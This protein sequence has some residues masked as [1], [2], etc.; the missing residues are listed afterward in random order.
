MRTATLT[1]ATKE[2]DITLS[3]CLDGSGATD[4]HTQIG[5]FDHMLTALA[6]HA[7]F[8][9]TIDAR[10][11]IQVDGHHTVED[12]GIL[13][14]QA[15]AGALGGRAGIARYGSAL[16]PMDEALAQA[17]ADISGR[18]YLVYSASFSAPMIG[19]LSADLIEEFWRAFAM[20]AGITLHLRL[21]YGT[22]DHHKAEAV[23]KAAAHALRAAAAR[24]SD[25][26]PL[27]SKGVL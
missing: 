23:F 16:I 20:Q 2:T 24:T 12:V 5:F 1:R 19:G 15:F 18:P 17:V 9:L 10:G 11:D 3:L 4:I 13:L 27:S 25:A 26:R 8:D 14:G 6:V 7:G 21:L 22:N